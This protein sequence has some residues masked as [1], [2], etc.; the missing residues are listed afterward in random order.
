VNLGHS[1]VMTCS[2]R[3]ST[4]AIFTSGF[5]QAQTFE[6]PEESRT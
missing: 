2:D 5:F 4:L 1:S 3:S 6:S